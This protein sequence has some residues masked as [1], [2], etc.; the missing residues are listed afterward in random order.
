MMWIVG[1]VCFFVGCFFG[2]ALMCILFVSRS[3]EE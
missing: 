3:R 2:V 1:I